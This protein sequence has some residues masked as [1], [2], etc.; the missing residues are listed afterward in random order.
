MVA[1]FRSLA[2]QGKCLLISSHELEEL[3]KLTD[4]VAIMARGRIAA[5]DT[6][7]RIRDRLADHPLTI[8]IDLRKSEGLPANVPPLSGADRFRRM[9]RAMGE[10]QEKVSG[11]D[12]RDLAAVL[13]YTLPDVLGVE[14]VDGNVEA[15]I[16]RLLVR[17]R[18]TPRFFQDLNRLVLEEWYDVVHLETLD[19]STQA[20]LGYLLGR[21]G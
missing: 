13:L 19:D 16:G 6:V 9:S 21:K 7:S 8:R 2:E 3:E 10:G 5:A 20:V 4:H 12:H 15:G 11:R 17:A 1:L 14:L 18:N